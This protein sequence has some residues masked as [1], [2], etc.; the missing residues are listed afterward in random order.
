MNGIAPCLWFDDRAEEAAELYTGIFPGSTVRAVSRFPESFDNPSG[1]P[2]GSVMT[3]EL[4]LAGLAFTALNGGPQF[5][6]NPSISFF[7]HTE[8]S[9]E[10][11]RIFAAL[12]DGGSILMPLQEYPWSE[13]FAW[14]QDRNGVSWQVILGRREGVRQ[15]IVPCLMFSGAQ[16][17]RAR[18]AMQRYSELFDH[19]R[20]RDVATYSADEGP[21]G[22]I[23]HGRFVVAG[24]DF[25]A[26][27]GH[28]DPPFGFN[29]AVS[30]QVMCEDQPE[31][32][33]YW[34]A[35]SDGG[36]EG[37]CGWLKDRFGVSW[38]VVPTAFIELTKRGDAAANDRMFQSM[39]GMKKLD[40]A[41]LRAAHERG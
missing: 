3:V 30:L 24:Q 20:L 8:T 7:V 37:P 14:V 13:R 27:D 40:I 41:A 12:A 21:E 39:L 36:E 11:D 22:M 6:I 10:T 28:V 16:H 35:L 34:A 4:E 25:V 19:S 31:V 17:G 15:T 2:P 9:E 18:E 38:Q 32:D 26:M 1:K 5:T 23:K 33:R 29:E